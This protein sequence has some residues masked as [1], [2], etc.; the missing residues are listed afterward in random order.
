M[1][2]LRTV[3]HSLQNMRVGIPLSTLIKENKNT[4]SDQ[5]KGKRK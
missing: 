4:D 3:L 2:P 5:N 1:K